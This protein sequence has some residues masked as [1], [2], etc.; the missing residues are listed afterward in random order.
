M[1]AKI[2][3]SGLNAT[4]G[5]RQAISRNYVIGGG[6][7]QQLTGRNNNEI[8]NR[9]TEKRFTLLTEQKLRN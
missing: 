7:E 3:T 5:A 8:C 9:D 1:T 2:S 4:S 6:G